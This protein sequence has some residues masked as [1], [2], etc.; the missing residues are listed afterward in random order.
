MEASILEAVAAAD[1]PNREAALAY[2]ESVRTSEAGFGAC[3]AL[4]TAP[5]TAP[6]PLVFA[7]HTVSV[8]AA[9]L[10]AA[11]QMQ[12]AQQLLALMDRFAR[13]PPEPL[14]LRNARA[15]TAAALFCRVY[16]DTYPGFL[17][18]LQQMAGS[19]MG[20]DY[21]QRTL[22]GIHSEIGDRNIARNEETAARNTRLK[23]A[24]RDRDMAGIVS[25][26]LAL[27][28]ELAGD[29][30]G[31]EVVAVTLQNVAGYISWMEVGL[32]VTAPWVEVLR[33]LVAV[34]Q[35]RHMAYGTLA[36]IAAK[37]MPPLAKL[38][39]LAAFQLDE[40][41]R[42]VDINA[43]D[44][45]EAEA[46]A[47]LATQVGL[48]LVFIM[49]SDGAGDAPAQ[50]AAALTGIF[51]FLLAAL[52]HEYDDV[53]GATFAFWAAYLVCLR[54]T[55]AYVD[56]ALLL[57][58]LSQVVLKMK[59]DDEDNGMESGDVEAFAEVR[60]RLRTFQ[61]QIALLAPELFLEAVLVVVQ[62][63]VFAGS[64]DW[65]R[66][67]LGLFELLCLSD[68]LRAAVLG[69][70]APPSPGHTLLAE[71]LAK[72]VLTDTPE[73]PLVQGAVLELC[74]RHATQLMPHTNSVL[75]RFFS[76]NGVFA[77]HRPLQ[78]RL[79]YLLFRFVRTAQVQLPGDVLVGALSQLQPLMDI[80]APALDDD[81]G[82]VFDQQVH[83]FEA[84]GVLAR[85]DAA[86]VATLL[87]PLVAGLD[88]QNPLQ[89]HH[90][91]M[92]IGTV[93]RGV[94]VEQNVADAISAQFA[95]AGAAILA[96]LSPASHPKV[97][98]AVRFLFA[99]LVTVARAAVKP[100]L[101]QMVHTLLQCDLEAQELGDIV[102]F[103][104]QCVHTYARDGEVAV[105]L[106]QA[107]LPMVRKAWAVVAATPVDPTRPDVVRDRTALRRG[108]I[109]FLSGLVLNQVESV[110]VLPT[111]GG[112]LQEVLERVF[113]EA[114]CGEAPVARTAVIAV[115]NMVQAVGRG[116]FGGGIGEWLAKRVVRMAL[117]V[118]AG[119]GFDV[120]DAQTRMVAQELAGCLREVWVQR[121]REVVEWLA[122]GGG[123]GLVEALGR[124]KGKEWKAE[125]V[126][127]VTR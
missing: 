94:S 3:L 15:A 36:G 52:A 121:E 13:G 106:D 71:L 54:R 16:P 104:G 73:H 84:V 126:R 83:L 62:Q 41:L 26:W 93:A 22:A 10:P 81:A 116:S 68:A 33:R 11:A 6:Q 44:V 9:A 64:T 2:L 55:R 58:L 113:E 109:Q 24:I 77:A 45:E 70:K 43:V 63:L 66:T 110:L 90:V 97:R 99:R 56:G 72:T 18:D 59:Y 88:A 80:A 30:A 120:R 103:V 114:Y 119:P 46:V 76:R 65:R 28:T 117:E 61:E 96:R 123:G 100:Q 105:L 25:T 23:D 5:N 38:L 1:G 35:H 12:V 86:A 111:N 69:S 4:A 107:V 49:E 115:G 53:S 37:K 42:S 29:S 82:D 50:A 31:R 60:A 102:A 89:L 127:M 74:V 19:V 17:T 67:E 39:L 92:A 98:E 57:Q 8:R 34:P 85:G 91:I 87:A 79:W 48:E 125:Y 40:V 112:G 20:A 32:V 27:L 14:F 122:E 47:S 75:Q 21:V 108:W 7:L 118:P 124:G 101:G 78:L 95:E 51:P